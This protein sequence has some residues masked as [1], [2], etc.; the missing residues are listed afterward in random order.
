ML[1]ESFLLRL[2]VMEGCGFSILAIEIEGPITD[3]GIIF[4]LPLSCASLP[5]PLPLPSLVFVRCVLSFTLPH[6]TLPSSTIWLAC[7]PS[8]LQRLRS[9]APH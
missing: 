2:L 6:P 5:L 8:R 1:V 4:A 9:S 7:A 3:F